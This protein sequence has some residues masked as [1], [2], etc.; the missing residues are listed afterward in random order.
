[1][2][3]ESR[4]KA[5]NSRSHHLNEL[6]KPEDI[7][8]ERIYPDSSATNH[9]TSNLDNLN[10]EN[11]EYRGEKPTLFGKLINAINQEKS[12]ECA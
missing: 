8:D 12:C 7:Q 11:K 1:M 9:A 2:Q 4:N 3:P 10:L 5:E 6:T